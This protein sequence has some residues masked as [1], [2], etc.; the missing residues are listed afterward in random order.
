MRRVILIAFVLLLALTG[1]GSSAD[2]NL[3]NP[4]QSQPLSESDSTKVNQVLNDPE[5]AGAAVHRSDH[6]LGPRQW[7][8]PAA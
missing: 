2:T 5:L 3:G 6:L 7:G 4:P 8:S 1:C